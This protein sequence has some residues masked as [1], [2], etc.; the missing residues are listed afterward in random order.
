MNG[1]VKNLSFDKF[2]VVSVV[3]ISNVYYILVEEYASHIVCMLHNNFSVSRGLSQDG[4][5]QSGCLRQVSQPET[6]Q[7]TAG[8]F[9]SQWPPLA[10]P[11]R[12][13]RRGLLSHTY[14]IAFF[15]ILQGKALQCL[16]QY[17]FW[18]KSRFQACGTA[19]ALPFTGFFP[20][21][22]FHKHPRARW[23]DELRNI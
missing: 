16:D 13:N 23:T 20:L 2:F 15:G 21:R 1:N 10:I 18:V 3:A 12:P 7:K 22:N 11:S 19:W 14:R 4:L 8:K 9:S 17:Q 5:S 6:Q